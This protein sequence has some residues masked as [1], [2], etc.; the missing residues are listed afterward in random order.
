MDVQTWE[1]RSGVVTVGPCNR[2]I[3]CWRT[4]VNVFMWF[5]YSVNCIASHRGE[6]GEYYRLQCQDNPFT[7]CLRDGLPSRSSNPGGGSIFLYST[8]FIRRFIP[9]G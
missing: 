9:R 6:G 1:P 4:A 5:V 7:D 8:S 3:S 2:G